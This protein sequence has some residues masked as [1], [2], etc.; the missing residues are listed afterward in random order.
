MWGIVNTMY[1][2]G[3]RGFFKGASVL[4]MYKVID[5]V[6]CYLVY[7]LVKQYLFS[8]VVYEYI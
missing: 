5:Q 3:A 8:R 7:S 6:V 4:I 2:N 1:A